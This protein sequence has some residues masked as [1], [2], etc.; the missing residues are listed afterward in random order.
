[1][2]RRG[3]NPFSAPTSPVPGVGSFLRCCGESRSGKR[4]SGFPWA[5]CIGQEAPGTE[6]T[7]HPS[8]GGLLTAHQRYRHFTPLRIRPAYDH[9]FQHT[10]VREQRPLDFCW[11]DVFCACLDEIF[12]AV[13]V[14]VQPVLARH[15][16]VAHVEPA[17][18]KVVRIRLVR[19]PVAAE[20]GGAA[21]C[22]FPW[23]TACNLVPPSSTSLKRCSEFVAFARL[24]G[25]SPMA[26]RVPANGSIPVSV[27]PKCSSRVPGRR[28]RFP[29]R[30][31]DDE[32]RKSTDDLDGRGR[33]TAL[34]HFFHHAIDHP[35]QQ[36]EPPLRHG[37][38]EVD[39]AID[40]RTV[41]DMHGAARARTCRA[42]S[43]ATM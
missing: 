29:P 3:S 26:K 18:A 15:K 25:R 43:S 2:V 38:G 39:D 8:R 33:A 28:A 6:R 23:L 7:A 11:I 34:A 5:V 27:E 10:R 32:V 42:C 41:D 36:H 22:H 24:A 30:A 9:G 13:D 35:G 40:V 21:H 14:V 12:H 17:A 4:R 20:N 31:S 19:V 1:M 16:H 37:L